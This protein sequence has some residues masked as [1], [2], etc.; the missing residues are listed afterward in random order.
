ME[1]RTLLVRINRYLAMCGVASRRSAEEL[2]KAGFV[3]VNGKV[4]EDLSFK[5]RAWVDRVEFKGKIILPERQVYYILNKPCCYLSSLKDGIDSKKGLLHLIRNIPERVF[6]VGRL[7]Y[8]SEG[9]MLLTND[10]ELALRV[11]HPRYGLEKVYLVWVDKAIKELHVRQMLKGA[12]LEDGFFSPD[13]VR[14]IKQNLLEITLHEGRKHIVKRFVSHFGYRV[15]RLL[16]VAIGPLR[17]GALPSGEYR[18]LK[19]NELRAL[20]FRLY[21]GRVNA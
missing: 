1:G 5:V 17:L 18:P 12:R 10:G 6:P 13:D 19:E 16:R 2:I 15:V 14:I 20:K 21:Q 4:V 7:D 8:N 3:K 9:L 11:S